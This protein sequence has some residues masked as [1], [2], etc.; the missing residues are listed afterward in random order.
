MEAGNA[1]VGRRQIHYPPLG[2]PC[3]TGN[4]Q[5]SSRPRPF[6]SLCWHSW[7]T[8]S[9]SDAALSE[10]VGF[11]TSVAMVESFPVYSTHW[12]AGLRWF[13]FTLGGLVLLCGV[14]DLPYLDPWV[15]LRLCLVPIGLLLPVCVCSDSV[16]LGCLTSA[17][18][19]LPAGQAESVL[20]AGST[21]RS[22][23]ETQCPLRFPSSRY[24]ACRPV[25]CCAG[26]RGHRVPWESCAPFPAGRSGS[27]VRSS[28][29]PRYPAG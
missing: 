5:K 13:H 11:D 27:G 7:G 2:C 20:Q 12:R 19:G 3:A 24:S 23:G 14:V 29:R 6:L 10:G 8:R 1:A 17:F 4:C 28:C 26:G 16:D 21:R 15:T 22:V 9:E 25:T 18:R